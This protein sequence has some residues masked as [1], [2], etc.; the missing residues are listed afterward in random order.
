[1]D[2]ILYTIYHAETK[3]LEGAGP[4]HSLSFWGPIA[5]EGRNGRRSYRRAQKYVTKRKTQ[6]LCLSAPRKGFTV[7]ISFLARHGS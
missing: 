2:Y 4:K 5:K 6:D 1:M 7:P 3:P